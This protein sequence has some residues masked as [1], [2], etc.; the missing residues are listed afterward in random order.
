[1][2]RDITAPLLELEQAYIANQVA[3]KTIAAEVRAKYNALIR[4]EIEDRQRDN[5]IAFA[6][7]LAR[8]KAQYELPVTEIQKNVLHTSTWARWTYWRD[9][10][11]VEPERVTAREARVEAAKPDKYY[12]MED[13]DVWLVSGP[14]GAL[15]PPISIDVRWD[16]YL[17]SWEVD[18]PMTI[19]AVNITPENPENPDYLRAVAAGHTVGTLF[20]VQKDIRDELKGEGDE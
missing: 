15:E 13:G 3:K 5:D 19:G 17:G 20:K 1:M 18:V 11:G 16:E 6:Q 7:H 9:L 12:T 14:D 2:S 4:R 10:A 8:V